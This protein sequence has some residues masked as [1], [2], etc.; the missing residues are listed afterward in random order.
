MP[1]RKKP[2]PLWK[3]RK[4]PK[5]PGLHAKRSRASSGRHSDI[6]APKMVPSSP[7]APSAVEEDWRADT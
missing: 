4:K 2:K 6:R 1:S 5:S 7:Y 3:Q